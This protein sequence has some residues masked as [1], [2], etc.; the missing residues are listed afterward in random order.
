MLGFNHLY[1]IFG[2]EQEAVSSFA[3]APPGRAPA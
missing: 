2:S 3:E 1:R